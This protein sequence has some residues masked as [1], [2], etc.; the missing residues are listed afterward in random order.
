MPA[1]LRSA[2][3]VVAAFT[4]ACTPRTPEVTP[5]PTA[6]LP[7]QLRWFRSAAEYPAIT[8][9]VYRQA[10]AAVLARGAALPAGSWAVILDADETVLDNSEYERRNAIAGTSF[11]DSTWDE[12]V[13]E[14]S[15]TPIA[16]AVPFIQAV[17]AAGGRIV[18][19]TNRG[20]NV[21]DDTRA[22]LEQVGVR[23]ALVL[24]KTVTSDKLPRF[25][26]V[27]AGTA[28]GGG[29]PLTIVAW[30][31]DNIQDFPGLTQR[32]RGDAAL[33]EPFGSRWFIL[34]NPLYGSWERL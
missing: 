19:V 21:C 8:L 32:A 18:I 12:W 2:L 27:R 4:L 30:V 17:Q 16:G 25:E 24:C 20:E 33:M 31:G 15:A 1:L 11:A 7:K 26:M 10:T 13:R 3:V 34:P 22:N 6:T 14:R 23:G 29:G 28:P 5:A 9:Q